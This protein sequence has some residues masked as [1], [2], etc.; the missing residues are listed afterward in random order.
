MIP[1]STL[2]GSNLHVRD[3]PADPANCQD[4]CRADQHC[5]SWT[6]S[7]PAAPG[8][9]AHCTL[10]AVIPQQLANACCTSGI[11]RAPD[12]EL[13]EAPEVPAAVT[14]ALRGVDLFGGDYHSFSG[15]RATIEGCQAACRADGE[16]LSWTYVRPGIFPS[17][18][19]SCSLK[20]RIPRQVSSTCCVSGVERQGPAP[21]R[22]P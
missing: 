2:P 1:N 18:E 4:A 5:A 17:G 6:Y 3:I 13:R 15:A 8:Q 12:P 19:Q 10:K 11:E 22:Q 16:C 14:N 20:G 21:P 7:Q 9:P